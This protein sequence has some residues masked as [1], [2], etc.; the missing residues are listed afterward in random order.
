MQYPN[1]INQINQAWKWKG[2]KAVR[3]EKVNE[4]GN[5]I[6][7]S[8]K[9]DY[10]RICPEELECKLI[11]TSA[12]EFEQLLK[13]TEFIEDWK[14]ES[15]IKIASEKLGNLESHEKYYLVMPGVLGGKYEYKNIRKISFNELI[16]L[17]GD[18]AYQ[19][20]DLKDGQKIRLKIKKN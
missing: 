18:L 13:D 4:F 1:L 11:A 19:I 12:S 6:F 9:N 7:K 10:W 8:S 3:I 15:L 14:M 16:S 2:V 20:K 17:S 5:I